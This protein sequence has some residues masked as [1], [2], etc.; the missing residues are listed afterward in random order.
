[1]AKLDLAKGAASLKNAASKAGQKISGAAKDGVQ[2]IS[3][4][5]HK[6]A[7]KM[8]EKN[9][10]ARI[11]KYNPLFPEKYN[12]VQ[13]NLPNMVRIVDD[14][15]RKDIDVCVGA[16]GWLSDEKNVEVLHLYDEAIEFSGL[17]FL[18]TPT[19]DSVYYVDPHDR[20]TFINIDT[21]FSNMQQERLAELQHIAFSLGA[22]EYSVEM[23]E[24][25]AESSN[26]DNV[27]AGKAQ[28]IKADLSDYKK[29]NIT[30]QSHI[31]AKATFAAGRKPTRPT[32]C[33]F[34]NDNNIVNLINMCCSENNETGI[35][36][37]SFELNSSCAQSMS[38]ATAVKID[39][40]IKGMGANSNFNSESTKEHSRKMIFHIVF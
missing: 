20:K 15:V 36:S 9:Y 28:A 6:Y 7:D 35:K 29:Q 5:T 3:D 23:I 27:A 13:F 17:Q 32:L 21:Y 8:A 4:K 31:A 11:K 1:M 26:T 40:A 33:W 19:C 22:K 30:T 24:E 25:T 34:A 38:S 14:A 18:P 10:G 37:Y 39:A 16:I 2:T 12:D